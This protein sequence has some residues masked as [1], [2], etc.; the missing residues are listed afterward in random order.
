MKPELPKRTAAL[1]APL[2]SAALPW[3]EIFILF[4]ILAVLTLG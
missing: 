2:A 1:R 3:G 4:A